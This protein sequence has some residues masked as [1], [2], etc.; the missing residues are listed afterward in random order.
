MP[1]V[2]WPPLRQRDGVTCG[3]TV[4]IVAAA[5]LDADY[6]ARLAAPEWFAAEQGR[7]HRRLNR[8]WPRALGT[9]PMA[10]AA[11]LSTHS[12]VRYRWRW[13]RR[14]DRL[15]DVREAVLLGWPV[16]MLVGNVA[17]RHWVLLT[18]WRDDGFACYEP[19][20]GQI[21]RVTV[22]Q[23]RGAELVGLGFARPWAF[24]LPTRLSGRFSAR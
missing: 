14:R 15:L 21:R 22:A 16:P 13:A 5:R 24:V 7:L 19:S 23:V 9:T 20:S 4:A 18:Q 8:C 1:P 17:P 2:H 12:A 6:A 10:M 11:A 3:P